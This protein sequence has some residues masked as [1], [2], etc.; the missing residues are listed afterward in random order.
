MV[1]IME[2]SNGRPRLGAA[3][4]EKFVK[5]SFNDTEHDIIDIKARRAGLSKAEYVRKGALKAEV[6]SILSDEEKGLLHELRKLGSNLNQI[7]HHANA[8]GFPGV[9]VKSESVIDE[10]TFLVLKL[11]NRVRK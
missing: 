5:V 10:I 8:E 11:K 1:S 6:A 3:K 7:A 2:R 4:R 9:A